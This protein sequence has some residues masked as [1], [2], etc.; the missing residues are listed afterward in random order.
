MNLKLES[1]LALVTASSGGIGL[2]IATTLAREGATVIVNG[3]SASSVDS[4]MAEIRKVVPDARLE[5]L[6]ADN[7]TAEGVSRRP[8]PLR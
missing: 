6:A 3:R 8:I 2:K 1:Q 4:A 5:S 7:G